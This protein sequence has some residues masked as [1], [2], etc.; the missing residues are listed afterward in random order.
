MIQ[1]STFK[2]AQIP[3]KMDMNLPQTAIYLAAVS[4]P[5]IEVDM[6]AVSKVSS[7]NST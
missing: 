2:S 5:I 4:P 1:S 6:M 3:S 7:I